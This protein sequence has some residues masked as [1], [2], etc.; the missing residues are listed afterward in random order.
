M[1]AFANTLTETV[2]PD[3]DFTALKAE[4]ADSK[5]KYEDFLTRK[6]IGNLHSDAGKTMEQIA[7]E[8]GFKCEKHQVVTKDGYILGIYRIPG[9]LSENPDSS[10]PPVL[11]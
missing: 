7:N 5:A 9:K 2:N 8:N 11:L 3:I 4:V 6:S 10:K 1:S